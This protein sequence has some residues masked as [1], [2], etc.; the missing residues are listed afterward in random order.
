MK[1][2]FKACITDIVYIEITGQSIITDIKYY[3]I[4]DGIINDNHK[5]QEVTHLDFISILYILVYIHID[6]YSVRVKLC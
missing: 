6:S 5:Y 3:C 4:F 2:L 1:S